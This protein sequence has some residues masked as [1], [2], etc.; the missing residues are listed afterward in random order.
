MTDVSEAVSS[1]LT[2]QGTSLLTAQEAFELLSFCIENAISVQS[3]EAYENTPE[4][5]ILNMHYSILG[6]DRDQ[7]DIDELFR[8]K[9][10]SAINDEKDIRFQ[11]WLLR[12]GPE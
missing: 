3:V 5:E 9:L 11:V 1:G 2:G 6:L 10:N 7:P 8:G 4:S 12:A